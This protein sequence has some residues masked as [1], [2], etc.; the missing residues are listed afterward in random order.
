MHR[1]NGSASDVGRM[2]HE[3]MR[4]VLTFDDETGFLES[5]DQARAGDLG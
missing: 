2:A 4:T 5:V 3:D 1:N